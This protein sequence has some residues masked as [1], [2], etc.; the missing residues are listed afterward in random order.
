MRFKEGPE[1]V[2]DYPWSGRPST[3]R[4][5]DN[6]E[7]VKQMVHTDRRLMVRMIA[8]ELSFN[9]DTVWSIIT[10]NLEI[11]KVCKDGPQAVVRGPETAMSHCLSRHY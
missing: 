3:S 5:V 8:E 10:E 1:E 9:K 2:E 7:R 6:I 4:T 11:C